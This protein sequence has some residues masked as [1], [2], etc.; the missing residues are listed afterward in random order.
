MRRREEEPARKREEEDEKHALWE[1]RRIVETKHFQFESN[2]TLEA[3]E[4][5]MDIT[6]AYYEYF[7]RAFKIQLTQR[8]KKSKLPVKL[9]SGTPSSLGSS[10]LP[11][12]CSPAS[13]GS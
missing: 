3:L 6:E 10:P 9:F 5:Y 11:W 4:Y 13:T 8:E 2:L 7:T 1:N 12:R